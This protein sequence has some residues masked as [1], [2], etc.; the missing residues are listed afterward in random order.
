[1]LLTSVPMALGPE[2]LNPDTLLTDLGGVALWVGALIIF[3]E[4][5]LLLGFFLP[6][7]SLLFTIGL[8]IGRGD[9][10]HSLW[11]AC[12]VLT[13]AAFLGN[14]VGYE[15]GRAAGPAIFKKENSKLFKREYV[16]KTMDFFDHYGPVAIVLARFTP[17][18]RTFI[19]VTAGVGKMDRRKYLTYSAIGALLWAAGITLLGRALGGIP[20]FRDHIE[21]G[22]LLLVV[23][24]VIPMAFEAWRHKRKAADADPVATA[25]AA[26]E[27]GEE[28]FPPPGLT[29]DEFAP[30]PR[31]TGYDQYN[32]F[33]NNREA[34][35]Y[36]DWDAP[37][38]QYGGDATVPS[39][40]PVGNDG[41][42]QQTGSGHGQQQYPDH[43]DQGYEGPR[44][45]H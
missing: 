18:V 41:Y 16:D 40:I 42:G 21:A 34:Q 2:W 12:A 1:M 17:L 45:R 14:V 37:D 31:Q 13:V 20:L 26:Q 24:S 6:G 11:F 8:F 4:C 3:A 28:P 43:P 22:L 38:D 27:A 32:G 23:V 44:R 39:G 30:Q 7:D 36:G 10:D 35:G 29:R 25:E 9:I 33:S 19:T 15:I 5:G